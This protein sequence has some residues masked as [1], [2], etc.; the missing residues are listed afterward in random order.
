MIHTVQFKSMEHSR[1][2]AEESEQ[3]ARFVNWLLRANKSV[4]APFEVIPCGYDS[5]WAR[6]V[7]AGPDGLD[8]YQSVSPDD[9]IFGN[10]AFKTYFEIVELDHDADPELFKEFD[11][12]A[13]NTMSEREL[14]FDIE[15]SIIEKDV[16]P[17]IATEDLMIIAQLSAAVRT[18]M[19]RKGNSISEQLNALVDNYG[20]MSFSLAKV[21]AKYDVTTRMVKEFTKK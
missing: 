4:L 14:M 8:D 2:F 3:N 21:I 1:V 13:G 18:F 5:M 10:D 16:N 17:D 9:P 19:I 15:D 12:A 7:Y 11:F 6:C 20:V